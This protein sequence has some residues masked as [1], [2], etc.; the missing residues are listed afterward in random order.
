LYHWINT[1]DKYYIFTDYKTN[2]D[3]SRLNSLKNILNRACCSPCVEIIQAVDSKESL[4]LQLQNV[5]MG[6]VGY[7]FNYGIEGQ[8]LAKQALI[9]KIELHLG[10]EISPTSKNYKKFNVFKINLRK[11]IS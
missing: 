10:H 7:K 3:G 4:L 5:L 8:S 6:A 11:D 2:K 1:S 9:K